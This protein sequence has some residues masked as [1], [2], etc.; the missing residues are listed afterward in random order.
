MKK[1][2][3]LPSTASTLPR[4]KNKGGGVQEVGNRKEEEGEARSEEEKE[5]VV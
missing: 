5:K 3:D 1:V 4:E 2:G